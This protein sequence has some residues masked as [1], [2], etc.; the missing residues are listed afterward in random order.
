MLTGFYILWAVMAVAITRLQIN[1]IKA[2]KSKYKTRK[3]EDGYNSHRM[4]TFGRFG[5][6]RPTTKSPIPEVILISKMDV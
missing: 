1:L 5:S 6:T 3:E 2:S 4:N